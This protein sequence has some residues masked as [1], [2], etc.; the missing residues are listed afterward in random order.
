MARI[1]PLYA[2][3]P[4]SHGRSSAEGISFPLA[5]HHERH[6]YV[7]AATGYDERQ[8]APRDCTADDPQPRTKHR[9]TSRLDNSDIMVRFALWFSSISGTGCIMLIDELC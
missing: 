7:H 4:R 8:A 3:K 9:D 1:L 2:S 5:L 6:E